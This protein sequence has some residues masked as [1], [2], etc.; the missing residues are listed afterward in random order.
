MSK[1]EPSNIGLIALGWAKASPTIVINV[2]WEALTLVPSG[3]Q[4]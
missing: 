3:I 1:S 4:P 2:P